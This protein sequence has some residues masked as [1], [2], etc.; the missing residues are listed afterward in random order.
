MRFESILFERTGPGSG[1]GG[2]EE[3]E[4]FADL[5]LDQVLKSMTAGRGQYE[6]EPLFWTPL[7]EADAVRYRH[8]VLRDLEKR[9][10]LEPVNR[11]A[12]TMRRMRQ[13]LEQMQKLH[14]QLQKQA[15]FLDA[16]EIYCQAVRA[17]AEELAARDVTSRG[18][19]GFA[20]LPRRV[21]RL[22]ALHL[23]GRTDAGAERRACADPVRRPDPRSAGHG[24]PLRG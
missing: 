9:E 11:F 19:H 6:L 12:E 13:H 8:E 2:P 10:V 4:F 22:G 15:W 24:Q 16:V 17:L 18:F 3:P 14:Y 5:N 21:R 1:V 20:P 23:A 7:H